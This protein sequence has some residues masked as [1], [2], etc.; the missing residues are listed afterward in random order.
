MLSHLIISSVT[1]VLSQE[2]VFLRCFSTETHFLSNVVFSHQSF[3]ASPLC[4][5]NVL[6]QMIGFTL[7]EQWL[8]QLTLRS[9]LSPSPAACTTTPCRSNHSNTSHAQQLSFCRATPNC[10][11]QNR[12]IQELNMIF[13]KRV[14]RRGL[15]VHP[16]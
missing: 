2:D 13:C 11:L 3:P 15:H 1:V 9:H 4:P 5:L 10:I 7:P 16:K 6:L 8:P 12:E 14:I